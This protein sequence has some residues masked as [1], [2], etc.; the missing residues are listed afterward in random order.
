V[1]KSKTVDEYIA[2]LPDWRS[3]AVAKVREIVR[4]AEPGLSEAIKWAQP[5]FERNGPVCYIRAFPKQVNFGFW[6]GA[7]LDDPK[8]LLLGDGAKM[9]NV[10][11][12]SADDIQA[13]QFAKWV[14]QAARLNLELGDPT[15]GE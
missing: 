15:K 2:S 6:R 7:M 11:I 8:G 14:K 5:V 1:A 9:R 13:G 3:E 10:K 4:K 12:T